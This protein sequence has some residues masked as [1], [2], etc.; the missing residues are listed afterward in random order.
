MINT[1]SGVNVYKSYTSEKQRFIKGSKEHSGKQAMQKC[2]T[3]T[4]QL[5]IKNML[6]G[7]H[8][9]RGATRP[10]NTNKHTARKKWVA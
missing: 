2:T 9:R 3:E 8:T 7:W 5:V 10:L 6:A 1:F 4:Q